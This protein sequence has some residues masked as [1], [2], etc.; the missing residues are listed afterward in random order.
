MT[1]ERRRRRRPRWLARRQA[2]QCALSPSI[3]LLLAVRAAVVSAGGPVTADVVGEFRFFPEMARHG[4]LRL[5]L[6]SHPTDNAAIHPE[7]AGFIA[8][9]G[10][11]LVRVDFLFRHGL[12]RRPPRRAYHARIGSAQ[13][14]AWTAGQSRRGPA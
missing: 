6:S 2:R 9:H 1:G 7:Q 5:C 12:K 4:V 3:M 8:A 13:L 11:R 14:I 10:L